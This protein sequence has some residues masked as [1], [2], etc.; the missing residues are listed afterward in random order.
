MTNRIHPQIVIES[1]E[2]SCCADCPFFSESTNGWDETSYYC[3]K[4]SGMGLMA[5]TFTKFIVDD[6]SPAYSTGS[7]SSSIWTDCPLPK[8]EEK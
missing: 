6:N 4:S 3:S 5:D 8:V 7:P 1:A 2:V